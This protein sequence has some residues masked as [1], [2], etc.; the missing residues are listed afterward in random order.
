VGAAL[1]NAA[2][3]GEA[4]G[5]RE[6]VEALIDDVVR[7]TYSVGTLAQLEDDDDG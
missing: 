6:E 7:L 2:Q 1:R 3:H 4:G 5:R